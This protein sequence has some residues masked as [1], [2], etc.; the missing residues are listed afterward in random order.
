MLWRAEK[1]SVTRLDAPGLLIGL[2]SEADYGCEEI[3][4]EPGDVILYYTDGVTEAQGMTGDRFDEARLI[5]SLELACR[6]HSG[7][8]QILDHLF[9]K[10]DGFVGSNHHLDDDA[11]MVV[12]K[13]DEEL[14]LPRIS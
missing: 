6:T 9:R 5:S 12:L 11:S 8:Q 4:L 3:V 14:A 10:L 2:Q 7:V 1:K 13:V